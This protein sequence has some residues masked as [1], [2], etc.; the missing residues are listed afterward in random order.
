MY[1]IASHII[2]LYAGMPFSNFVDQRIF[3]PLNMSSSTYSPIKANATGHFTQFWTSLT[4]GP[5]RIPYWFGTDGAELLEGPGGIISSARELTHWVA[6]LLDSNS[7]TFPRE[8][9]EEPMNAQSIMSRG[10]SDS[11]GMI[12][13]YGLGWMQTNAGGASVCVPAVHISFTI[14]LTERCTNSLYFIL[15]AYL[16]CRLLLL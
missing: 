11:L 13:T 10:S 8:A 6:A 9:L 16:E 12:A 3:I 14:T 2:S 7:T 1:M 15:A 4:E 5:R